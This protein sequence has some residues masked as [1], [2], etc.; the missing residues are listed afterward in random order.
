M[1]GRPHPGLFA[2]A[3]VVSAGAACSR[4]QPASWLVN[5]SPSLPR[6]VY[7]LTGEPA[8]RGAI[9]A[10][11]PP[12]QGGRYLAGLG[13][14]PG[15]RLLKRVAATP[16]ESVCRRGRQL[17]W[18]RG[19]VAALPRD[20]RGRALPQWR[21]CRS[22]AADEVLV[23]GDTPNSFDSRYFGPIRTSEIAGVYEEVWR[24]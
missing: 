22:L 13:A 4:A 1:I 2:A 20:R 5:E 18:P 3:V 24:W 7:R 16:G 11:T 9:V 14:P 12:P 6:G 21:G 23:L 10:L 19:W 8:S 15:A 17:T